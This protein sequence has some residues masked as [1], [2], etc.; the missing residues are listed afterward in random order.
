[1]R[2][3]S[4]PLSD[5]RKT[6]FT[7][8]ELLVVIGIIAVLISFLLPALNKARSSAAAVAC[9]SQLKQVG[10]ANQIYLV[11]NKNKMPMAYYLYPAPS[12]EGAVTWPGSA[13]YYIR[14]MS[15]LATNQKAFEGPFAC[16][17]YMG[18]ARPR[19]V[20]ENSI[21]LKT[22]YTYNI[23]VGQFDGTT[24]VQPHLQATQA[25]PASEKAYLMD[26]LRR[27]INRVWY[28][29]AYSQITNTTVM[30]I[31]NGKTHNLLFFDGHAEPIRTTELVRRAK[32]LWQLPITTP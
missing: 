15:G 16:K 28:A 26:G 19:V 22:S 8:V 30:G 18:E 1:M 29:V 14:Q 7:L 31:H 32:E 24:W 4:S 5:S 12:T 3:V 9:M 20:N 21:G 2:H 10:L 27:D 17:T 13:G 25:K 23:H 6:G 11:E